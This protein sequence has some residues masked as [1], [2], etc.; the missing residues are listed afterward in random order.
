M[1]SHVFRIPH[2]NAGE[3]LLLRAIALLAPLSAAQYAWIVIQRVSTPLAP[4]IP[5]VAPVLVEQPRVA[6]AKRSA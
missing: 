4:A 3:R 1:G 6:A 2:L 5:I